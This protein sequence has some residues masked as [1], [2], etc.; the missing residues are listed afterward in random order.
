MVVQSGSALMGGQSIP[1]GTTFTIVIDPDTAIE[2]IVDATAVSTNTLSI[3]RA[4]DGSSAQ[5]HSAGAVVRHMAIGRDYREANAHIEASTGVHGISNSSTIVGTIDTQTLTNKTLTSPTITSPTISGTNVDASIV[6]E[7]ATPD[8][9]ETTLTVV[10]PTQDNTIT[11]PNTTGTVV[12]A[13]AVQTL[14]NKTLTSPTISGSPVITGLSSAGMT[15]SSATPKDYVDSILG[16]ATAAATS[17][18]SAATSAASAATSAGSSETS[19]IA[20]AASATTSASSATAATTSATSAAA[21]ATAAATSA[22]SAAA[23]ATA[24]ATSATSAAASATASANSAT[25]SATSATASASSAS[26]AATSASSALTSQT[27]AATSATSAAASATAAATSATSAAASATAAA[28]S[29]T[30]AAA[31]A[32]TAAGYV[33]PTQTGNAGKALTTDGT[34][35]TWSATINGTAIPATK[36]LVVTTDKL[37]ALAATTSAELAGVISDETGTGAL[38]FANTPTLVTPVLGSAT[39]TSLALTVASGT[40]VP[41]TIQNN[42]TGDSFVV[43]DVASDTT[44]FVVDQSGNVAVGNTLSV[45]SL[46]TVGGS[47]PNTGTALIANAQAFLNSTVNW[48]YGNLEIRRNASNTSTPRF[49]DMILDGDSAESTTIGATNSIWGIYDSSPTTGSLS[50]TLNSVMGYGAYAGHRW[51]TNG[52]ERMRIASTGLVGIGVTPSGAMLHIVNNTAGNVGTIIKGAT[53]QS[54]DLLQVQNS[55]GTSLFEVDSAGNVGIGT[56]TTPAVTRLQ[57]VNANIASLGTQANLM[58]TTSDA[59]AANVGGVIGLGGSVTTASPTG[60]MRLFGAIRGAKDDSSDGYTNGYLAFY[61]MPSFSVTPAEHMRIDSSGNVG[62]GTSSPS[63]FGKLAIGVVNAASTITNTIGMYQSAGADNSTLRIAGYVYSAG[64]KTTIDF[65]QN[66]GTN[67]QTAMAFS[68][69]TGGALAEGMRITS[70]QNVGIGTTTPTA[71]LDVNGSI[72]SDNLSSNN[73]VLNSSFNVWQRGT[74]GFTPST[75]SSATGYSADRWFLV[76]A[77]F[78]AGS[79]VSRQLT[80]DTTNLPNIQYCARVQ[81]DSGNTSTAAV[82]MS[83]SFETMN[84]IPFA[85]KTVTLSFYARKGADYSGTATGFA[86]VVVSGTGTDQNASLGYTGFSSVASATPSAG[87]LASLTT[88]WQRF[89]ATGTVPTTS[90]EICVSMDFIP[91]GTAGANDYVEVTGV[92]LELG[93]VATPYQPNQSTYQAELAACQRYYLNIARGTGKTLGIV[94]YYNASSLHLGVSYPVEM[95]TAP[96]IDQVAGTNYFGVFNDGATRNIS[97]SWTLADVSTRATRIYAT[98]D[99]AAT[100]QAGF[101]TSTNA[102]AVLALSAEL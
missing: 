13:T 48:N 33:V 45:G 93:N 44:P 81:R 49:I 55:A 99:T 76:R 7:G 11:M 61:T 87:G 35:T 90:K 94:S 10:D 34:T 3:T 15:T 17:A 19:A 51:Y 71:K 38:V 22:T 59:Q 60:N 25:A 29:A 91:T 78:A 53:S 50:S 8:A 88:T 37:S 16:S 77:A 102:N 62:I 65:I 84:S 36:T 96:T 40:T 2:E 95:R 6:F 56:T 80:G 57:V 63:S 42:G 23:S 26:A 69:Y 89:T 1:A 100:G 73:A 28:T 5:A 97:G 79:T 66:S 18:A 27:A 41:L 32:T 30:S 86:G 58:V 14:T 20:S 68:T 85:G 75:G 82:G 46:T 72:K 4:I 101:A 83:Q 9:F 39:G 70:A 21:S 12:I 74:S 47:T 98:S 43:N 64:A 92:Q 67:F 54:A 31:S 52:T 24:A